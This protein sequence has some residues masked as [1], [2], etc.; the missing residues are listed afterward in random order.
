MFENIIGQENVVSL[1][2]SDITNNKLSNSMILY[3]NKTTGKLTTALELVRVL[4]CE[5]NGS[6]CLC[7]NCDRIRSLNFEGLIFLS[8]R[9]FSFQ[10]KEKLNSYKKFKHKKYLSDIVKIMKLIFLPLHDFIIDNSLNEIEKKQIS[11][12]FENI[13]DILSKDN[14]NSI[15]MNN[16]EKIVE[17]INILYKSLNI[18][19]N[20]IRSVLNWTHIPQPDIN[21]FVIMDH[22][23]HFEKASQNI[24][25][26]RLEEPSKNLYFILLAERKDK[27]LKTIL[28]RCRL[29]HFKKMEKNNVNFIIKSVYGIDSNSDSLQHFLLRNDD[30]SS[31]N[32]YPILM[33]LLNLVFIKEAT[34]SELNLFL[35][36][37]NNKKHVKSLLYEFM[38]LIEKEI[39]KRCTGEDT[40]PDL[41]ILKNLTFINLSLLKSLIA[42]K[43]NGIERN[44]L[45]PILT[46]EGIFYPLK[47]MIQNDQI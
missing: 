8:R 6:N 28:S 38:N 46:L 4:N 43:Y 24:L 13:N 19:I 26:K 5:T 15:D 23:E 45:N 31:E 25:L 39:L 37:Y 34:F 42:R 7:N 14:I 3:G 17:K 32:I 36:A 27:I 11:A 1:L 35:A 20:S 33:K 41:K 2:R 47:A 22:V 10:L 9:D 21:R 18:P 12:Q 30:T 40:I 16:L 29:Y 44:I